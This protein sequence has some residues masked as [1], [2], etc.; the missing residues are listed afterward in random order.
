MVGYL[1]DDNLIPMVVSPAASMTC[2]SACS[3]EEASP[4]QAGFGK[5]DQRQRDSAV[6][7]PVVQR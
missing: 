2:V 3:R 5:Q 7:R 1:A 6:N 4:H